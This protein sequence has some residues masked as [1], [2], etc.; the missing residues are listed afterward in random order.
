L[1]IRARLLELLRSTGLVLGA[2]LV[3][4]AAGFSAWRGLVNLPELLPTYL[5]IILAMAALATLVVL[6]F[7]AW[8]LIANVSDVIDAATEL[9]RKAAPGLA[10]IE[11]GTA[12][13]SET[14][15]KLST[16]TPGGQAP[17]R[18]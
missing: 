2:L 5:L 17:A 10:K 18:R 7:T 13:M 14:A 4:F 1:R 9:S 6:G 12:E 15:A 8:R 3:L 16:R 11:Q